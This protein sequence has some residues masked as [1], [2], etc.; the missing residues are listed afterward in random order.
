MTRLLAS[1]ICLLL[2]GCANPS[3][4]QSCGAYPKTITTLQ[5]RGGRV[6]WSHAHGLIAYD[7]DRNADGYFDVHQYIAMC[8]AHYDKVGLDADKI[9]SLFR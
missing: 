8:K 4:A 6:D 9:T 2:A 7:D 1:L 3:F 5:E